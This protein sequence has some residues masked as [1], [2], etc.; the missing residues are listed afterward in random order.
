MIVHQA[1]RK[2]ARAGDDAPVG[3]QLQIG[4]A[5]GIGEKYLLLPVTPLRHMVRDIGGNETGQAGH[6][7]LRRL[8]R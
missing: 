2:A 1:P 3:E 4:A 8:K 5:V 7:N 6:T